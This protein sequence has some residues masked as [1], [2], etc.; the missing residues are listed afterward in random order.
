MEWCGAGLCGHH[1]AKTQ[2]GA[3]QWLCSAHMAIA[4]STPVMSSI[5]RFI[6]ESPLGEILDSHPEDVV[7]GTQHAVD[8]PV[9]LQFPT[10]VVI[11][12]ENAGKSSVLE[13]RT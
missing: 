10:V 5:Q 2:R 8:E 12:Q 6:E 1:G 11:G 7:A 4:A 13:R 9:E 3:V